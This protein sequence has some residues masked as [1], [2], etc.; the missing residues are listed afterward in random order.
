M[1]QTDKITAVSKMQDYIAAHLDDEITLDAL[2]TAAGYSKYY[3]ARIFSEL[4]GKSPLDTVRALR[5]TR[6]A[7]TLQ[8]DGEKVVN[9]A[10]DSGFDS[11]DGFTRAF[12][13]QF[14]ITPQRYRRETPAV[15]WF[16]SHPIGAYYVLKEGSQA[17]NNEKV[18]RTVS[19][20]AVERP[21]RKLI[22]LRHKAEDYFSACEE[23]GCD[24]EG[25][26]NSIPERF[27]SAAGGRLPVSLADPGLVEYAFFVEVPQDYIKPLPDGYKIA[28]LPPCT[29]LYFNG[30]PYNDP[31]DLCIAIEI[32]NEAIETYPYAR[33]GWRRA[34]TAPV[35][36]M[37][38][39]EATGARTAIPVERA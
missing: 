14:D 23:V 30:M 25:F 35:L 9:V 26:Y 38:A 17:M 18:S 2:A 12:A 22:Y 31:N 24:W 13:R 37:G 34:D 21:A 10:L 8:S 15:Q 7:M 39:E 3:A 11:H 19:V 28:E 4:T 36:G 32:V 5:L 29:Y 33:F 6:A 16:V 1:E 27:D 20:T